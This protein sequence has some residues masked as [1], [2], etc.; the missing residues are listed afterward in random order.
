MNDKA[1]RELAT[2]YIEERLKTYSARALVF[3]VQNKF[4]YSYNG[5]KYIVKNVIDKANGTTKK[6]DKV[7]RKKVRIGNSSTYVAFKVNG[8]TLRELL[9]D[10]EKR[11]EKAYL[12]RQQQLILD[13]P[14]IF[15]NYSGR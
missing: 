11:E 4:G 1:R 5:A 8:K 14:K 13:R 2:K 15:I 12:E 7:T 6:K 3:N 10:I 9:E